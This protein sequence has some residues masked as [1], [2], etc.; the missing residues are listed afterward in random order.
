MEKRKC[1]NAA[2]N[3]DGGRSFNIAKDKQ[4]PY[5]FLNNI[6][7]LFFL[8]LLLS[9]YTLQLSIIINIYIYIYIS[10]T[11]YGVVSYVKLRG[12]F[13]KQPSKNPPRQNSLHRHITDE[14]VRIPQPY[15]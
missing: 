4:H 6:G 9:I 7:C 2:W 5:L 8:I 11:I 12:E 10:K 15:S 3:V 14:L 1:G 13:K